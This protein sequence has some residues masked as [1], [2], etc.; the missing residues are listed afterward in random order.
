MQTELSEL[1]A[2]AAPGRL[3][4]AALRSEVRQTLHACWCDVHS[5]HGREQLGLDCEMASLHRVVTLLLSP[6][7]VMHTVRSLVC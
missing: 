2:K 6:V 5:C 7:Y 1:E 4:L 3:D